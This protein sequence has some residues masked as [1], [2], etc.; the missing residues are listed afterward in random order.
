MRA[1]VN[2]THPH[3]G[4]EQVHENNP[5]VICHTE[6]FHVLEVCLFAEGASRGGLEKK[7]GRKLRFLSTAILEK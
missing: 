2:A 3:Q 4:N 6:L 5:R 1:T 7:S